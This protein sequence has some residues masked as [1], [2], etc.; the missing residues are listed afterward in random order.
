MYEV[1]R[2]RITKGEP[3]VRVVEITNGEFEISVTSE[4][5]RLTARISR[6]EAMRIAMF[7]TGRR[8]S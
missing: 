3:G 2:E 7:I 5:K 8:R 6:A 4:H 1:K